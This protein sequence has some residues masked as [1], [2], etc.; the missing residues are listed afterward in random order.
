M[1]TMVLADV[2][3]TEYALFSC[4]TPATVGSG[5]DALGRCHSYCSGMVACVQYGP[6]TQILQH[7]CRCP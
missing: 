6:L 1:T 5:E 7:I 2:F 4:P 3:R